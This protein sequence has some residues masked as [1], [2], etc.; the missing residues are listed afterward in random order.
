MAAPKSQAQ[1]DVPGR[2]IGKK[3]TVDAGFDRCRHVKLTIVLVQIGH[4]C[5]P[6]FDADAKC[7][8]TGDACFERPFVPAGEERRRHIRRQVRRHRLRMCLASS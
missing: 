6:F 4:S 5:F 7:R 1:G 8:I 3:A 2:A